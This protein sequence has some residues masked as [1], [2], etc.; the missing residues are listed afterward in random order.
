M[1]TCTYTLLISS[2][3]LKFGETSGHSYSYRVATI[4]EPHMSTDSTALGT[5][6]HL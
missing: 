3:H 5:F 6:R 2:T 4:F 1:Y